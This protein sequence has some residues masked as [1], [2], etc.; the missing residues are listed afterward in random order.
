MF[1]I[2]GL[3]RGDKMERTYYCIDMKTFFASVECAERGLDPFETSLV[4]AD[5]T[6]GK[7]ALC[8]A[9][10]PKMKAQGVW[11]RC[12]LSDIPKTVKY[13]IAPPRMALY[14]EYSADIYSVYLDYIDPQ[15]I[16]VYSIDEAFIDATKY[17]K[18]Y[19]KDKYEFAKLLMDE[20]SRRCHIPSTVGIGTNLYLAKI[21]LDIVAKH[22][23]DRIGY[24][25]EELYKK[26]LWRHRPITD[27]WMVAKGTAKRLEQYGIFDMHGITVMPEELVY[28][29]FGKDAELLID[30]AWGRETCLISDIK[31]Y[32]SKSRSVSFSQILPRD[33][34]YGEART[35]MQEMAMNGAAELMKRKEVT[36]R[37]AVYVG[38]THDELPPAK[39]MKKLD[40]TTNLPSFL[41]APVLKI[42]DAVVTPSVKV[43][44][45]AVSFD[46]VLDEDCERYNFFVDQNAIE[47]EKTLRQAV[48]QINQRFGRNAVLS[49]LNYTR[50]GTQRERNEF[51]GGHRAGYDDAKRKS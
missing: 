51:I 30:H 37:V 4:V 33:Y 14:I 8:L 34:T 5:V 19:K 32:K 28:R 6:R 16:H 23:K 17:F 50:E 38:Y 24:L 2:S 27:F 3:K 18:L 26:L 1:V 44:K 12:R 40:V 46:D 31:D 36:S 29:L 48:L 41:V 49:G 11:N 20:I 39:G 43:R 35:V 42:Y 47:K 45:L 21:A 13:E 9:V 25:D 22:A 7:N 15:D 10:T